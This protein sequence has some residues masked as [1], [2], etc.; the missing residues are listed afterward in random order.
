[1]VGTYVT[2]KACFLDATEEL[3]QLLGTLEHGHGVIGAENLCLTC[4][5]EELIA[6]IEEGD[7]SLGV[8]DLETLCHQNTEDTLKTD[9]E[10]DGR[11]GFADELADQ[12]VITAAAG[13]GAAELVALDLKNGAGVVAQ[14]LEFP[15]QPV[16]ILA[17]G[18]PLKLTLT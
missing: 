5:I 12:M 15:L 7:L 14:L 2:V 13:D 18:L 3:A 16:H 9:G 10:S 17:G 6:V 11:N 8:G 1:M 4:G